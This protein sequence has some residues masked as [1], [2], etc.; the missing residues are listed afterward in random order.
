M[1]SN[2]EIHG[3][4]VFDWRDPLATPKRHLEKCLLLFCWESKLGWNLPMFSNNIH[5]LS[6]TLACWAAVPVD[7][8]PQTLALCTPG[9][10]TLKACNFGL[11]QVH[12]PLCMKDSEGFYTSGEF[13]R[14][15]SLFYHDCNSSVLSLFQL[16]TSGTLAHSSAQKCKMTI[17]KPFIFEVIPSSQLK[18]CGRTLGG[19]LLTG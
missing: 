1:L 14:F 18:I 3:F 17:E 19:W 5:T 7:Q 10:R 15:L 16:S 4:P 2:H 12:F 9:P 8:H 11:G 13:Y 6:F